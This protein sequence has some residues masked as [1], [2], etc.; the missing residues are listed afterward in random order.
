[1]NT[2]SDYMRIIMV[3]ITT[4]FFSLLFD[5][6]E[7]LIA[8]HITQLPVL[9]HAEISNTVINTLSAYSEFSSHRSHNRPTNLVLATSLLSCLV[10]CHIS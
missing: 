1:M 8:L 2:S 4:M 3:T 6:I 9:N 7:K 10:S 5:Q